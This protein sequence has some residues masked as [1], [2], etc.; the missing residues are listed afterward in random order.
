[1]Y[2]QELRRTTFINKNYFALVAAKYHQFWVYY[3]LLNLYLS[4]DMNSAH[5]KFHIY[6]TVQFDTA[7]RKKHCAKP[8]CAW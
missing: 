5:Y 3:K 6:L 2:E 4:Y 7:F 8:V 1:M